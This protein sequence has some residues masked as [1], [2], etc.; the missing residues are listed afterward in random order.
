MANVGDTIKINVV[1]SL[2]NQ[3]TAIHFHG[4]FQENST[5]NDGPVGVTQCP[6]PPGS[7]KSSAMINFIAR[8]I[9]L[10]LLCT[11]LPF[12]N[13]VHTGIMHTLVVNMLVRRLKFV[14]GGQLLT[15]VIRWIPWPVDHP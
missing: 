12:G 9:S 8:L 14:L 2:F 6:I 13:P 5:L 10:Q 1:N 3:T 4:L 11:N 7:S 15:L